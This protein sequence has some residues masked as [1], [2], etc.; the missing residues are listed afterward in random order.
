MPSGDSEL[1]VSFTFVTRRSRTR[2]STGI[3]LYCQSVG[4][5]EERCNCY[6]G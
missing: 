4:N 1:H 2:V 5:L 6:N 3:G